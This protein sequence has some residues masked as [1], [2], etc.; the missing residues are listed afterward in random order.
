MMTD[1]PAPTAFF[2]KTWDETMALLLESRAYL[3]D[4]MRKDCRYDPVA[5][6][7]RMSGEMTRV[8]ARLTQ[9]MAWLLIQRAVHAGEVTPEEALREEHRLGGHAVC[10]DDSFEGHRRIPPTLNRLMKRSRR[11]YVRVARLD[12]LAGRAAGA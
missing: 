4:G 2:N 5:C 3:M 12:D 9:I 1:P 6:G 10:L 8:T 7:L 11:L